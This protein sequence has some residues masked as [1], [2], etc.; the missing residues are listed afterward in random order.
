MV[1][2]STGWCC[3]EGIARGQEWWRNARFGW[4]RMV[5]KTE[6]GDGDETIINDRSHSRG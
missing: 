5:A 6:N 1:G 4:L 2:G 3:R